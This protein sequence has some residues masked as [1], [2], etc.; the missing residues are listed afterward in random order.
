[1]FDRAGDDWVGHVVSGDVVL[2]MPEIGIELPLAEL[3]E[4]VSFV[5]P[6]AEG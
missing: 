4:G 1:M 3:Y 6:Q 2:A 5:E